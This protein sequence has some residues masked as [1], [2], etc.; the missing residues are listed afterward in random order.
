MSAIIQDPS[1]ILLNALEIARQ[2]GAFT[3]SE[4]AQI[5][6]AIQALE[7]ETQAK[8]ASEGANKLISQHPDI[9]PAPFKGPNAQYEETKS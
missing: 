4:S 2:R 6:G 7:K 8:Q 1:K 3:F 5:Y 9:S